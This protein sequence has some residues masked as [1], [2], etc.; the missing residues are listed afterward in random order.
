LRAYQAISFSKFFNIA[1]VVCYVICLSYN[2]CV[3]KTCWM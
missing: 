3:S 1:I 2:L